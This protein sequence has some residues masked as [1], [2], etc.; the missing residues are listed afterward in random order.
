MTYGLSSNPWITAWSNSRR[1]RTTDLLIG[2]GLILP[3]S[4]PLSQQQLAQAIKKSVPITIVSKNH[5]PFDPSD[6]DMVQRPCSVY[7]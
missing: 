5:P 2:E 4:L 1:P 3:I 7:S 6:D